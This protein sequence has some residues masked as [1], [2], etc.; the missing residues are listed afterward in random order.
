M[1]ILSKRKGDWRFSK[2]IDLGQVI[3]SLIFLGS[4][5]WWGANIQERLDILELQDNSIINMTSQEQLNAI[6]MQHIEISPCDLETWRRLN[7][8]DSKLDKL[9][10]IEMMNRSHEINYFLSSGC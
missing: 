7:S 8:I 9:I 10:T 4:L 2:K 6:K 1:G 3:A 5:F